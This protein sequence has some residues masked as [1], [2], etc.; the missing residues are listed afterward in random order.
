MFF[1]ASPHAIAIAV[2]AVSTP[3]SMAAGIII[4]A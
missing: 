2:L 1:Q 4:G 3:S